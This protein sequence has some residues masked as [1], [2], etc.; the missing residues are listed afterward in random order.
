MEMDF[1]REHINTREERKE[2]K[3]R[4]KGKKTKT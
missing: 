3:K 4:R 1:Q 2:E